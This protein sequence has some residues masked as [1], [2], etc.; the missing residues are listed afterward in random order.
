MMPTTNAAERI[1][2]SLRSLRALAEEL[3]GREG[4][5][6]E[7]QSI[8][9]DCDAIAGQLEALELAAQPDSE[10][11]VLPSAEAEDRLAA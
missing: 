3:E 11:E 10:V 7:A 9:A 8:H 4:M 2:R 1:E 5:W 6:L